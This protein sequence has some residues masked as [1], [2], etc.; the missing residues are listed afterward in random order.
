MS[1]QDLES[2]LTEYDAVGSWFMVGD[3][4]EARNLSTWQASADI[5]D[6]LREQRKASESEAQFA[7][8]RMPGTRGR[9]ARWVVGSRAKNAR[10]V[11]R[12]LY[13]DVERKVMRAFMPDLR[14]IARVNPRTAAQT[15][16]QIRSVIR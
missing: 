6:Y 3:Y 2:Y 1:W 16:R 8:Y 12:A 7:L 13:S 15:A 9:G 4:A 10:E 14:H 5:Q 11:G